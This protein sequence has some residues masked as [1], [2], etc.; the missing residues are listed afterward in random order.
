MGLFRLTVR[1]SVASTNDLV[2][3]AIDEGA[4]EGH[5]VLAFS[6]SA[7]YGRQGRVW[8]SP[9][10]GMYLS[11]LLRPSVPADRVA[12]VGLVVALS[13]RSAACKVFPTVESQVK[14][15]NDIVCA[16]GKLAG[17]SSEYRKGALCIGVGANVAVPEGDL[18]V[19]GKYVPAYLSGASVEAGTFDRSAIE[20]FARAVLE[21]LEPR[22]LQWCACGFEPFADEYRAC[23][24]LIGAQVEVVNRAGGPIARGAVEG[25]DAQGRLL[26]RADGGGLSAVASGEAHIAR[27]GRS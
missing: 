17:V 25:I 2:K 11:F 14:W 7:G 20:R 12:T 26:V 9:Y 13:V 6:Q 1:D 4:P 10:G 18:D 23:L 21:E 16:A 3:R 8:A 27:I 5:A 22:Y 24:S 15:P 19:G